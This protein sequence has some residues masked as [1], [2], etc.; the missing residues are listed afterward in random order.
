MV[1]SSSAPGR[2][3]ASLSRRSANVSVSSPATG[4]E[5]E[6]RTE[7]V[8][9]STP[10]GGERRE[11]GAGGS[12]HS[13]AAA[14]ETIEVHLEHARWRQFGWMLFGLVSGVLLVA[15]FGV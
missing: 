15:I 10:G 11:R 9:R 7:G 5:T 1:T 13:R 2:S 8:P 12:G 6:A 4:A 3:P 14:R